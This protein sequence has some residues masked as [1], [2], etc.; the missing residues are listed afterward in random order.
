MPGLRQ[1]EDERC[2]DS[3]LIQI[4]TQQA[5]RFAIRGELRCVARFDLRA[6]LW[7]IEAVCLEIHDLSTEHFP[8]CVAAEHDA[9]E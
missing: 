6:F 1:N 5:Q 4:G 2:A 8:I 9:V 3:A 7:R